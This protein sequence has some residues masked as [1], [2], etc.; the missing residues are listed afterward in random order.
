MGAQLTS[1]Q[2]ASAVDARD[3]GQPCG[4]VCGAWFGHAVALL[5]IVDGLGHGPRAA[6][7]AR[8][9][10]RAI[11]ADPFA[12]LHEIFARADRGVAAT[13]GAA[14]GLAR[15]ENGQLEY[16]AVGNTRMACLREGRSIRL[17]SEP[18]I[19]GEGLRARVET[20]RMEVVPGDWL[21]LCTDGIEDGFAVPAI[22]PEW[23]SDPAGLC[24]FVLSRFR[25]ARDDA[26]VLVARI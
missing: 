26:G 23:K 8:A 1:D 10:E 22:F 21:V 17:P 5:A 12:P 20:F 11:A 19:V 7:A 24:R 18:G 16:G 9:A 4:D 25:N 6:E 14:I 2:V 15:L 3:V 13:R